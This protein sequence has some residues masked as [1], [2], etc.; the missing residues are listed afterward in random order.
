MKKLAITLF[1][2][3]AA[4]TLTL[5]LNTTDVQKSSDVIQYTHGHTG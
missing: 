2:V 4:F 3:L 5:G 1:S